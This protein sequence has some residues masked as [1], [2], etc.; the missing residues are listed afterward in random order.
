MKLDL[1]KIIK[2]YLENF[3]LEKEKL[4]LLFAFLKKHSDY[5][6]FDWNNTNGHITV[7]AFIYC[8]KEDKFLVLEHK[9]LNMYLYPGGHVDRSDKNLVAAAKRELMEETNIRKVKL[10]SFC[11]NGVPFDI[12]IHLI[13]YN[14]RIKME[15]HWH[16]DFRYIFFTD[17]IKNISFDKEEISNYK[18]ISSKELFN[19]KNFGKVLEKIFKLV[20]LEKE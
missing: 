6:M 5:D 7:G 12:D 11:E 14:K 15:K 8:E 16:F 18:W 10:A 17:E 2:Q 9:D 1:K 19:D 4:S 20:V 3:P 13:P